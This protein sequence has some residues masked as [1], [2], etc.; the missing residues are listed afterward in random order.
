LVTEVRGYEAVW[1]RAL[2]I[3]IG[4]SVALA[5]LAPLIW[6]TFPWI[7]PGPIAQLGVAITAVGALFVALLVHKRW[8][9]PVVPAGLSFAE[10]LAC[11]RH[12][13]ELRIQRSRTYAWWHLLPILLGPAVFVLGPFL[14]QPRLTEMP[15]AGA[16]TLAAVIAMI[17]VVRR[18]S[19]NKYQQRIN[20]LGGVAETV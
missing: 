12:N 16:A 6:F 19:L 5:L 13:L 3:E 7:A 8:R 15:I 17:L 1:Q 4:M 10:T 20:Q 9:L 11:Y 14:W 18:A 2:R